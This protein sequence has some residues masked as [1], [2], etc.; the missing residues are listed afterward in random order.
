MIYIEKIKNKILN[1]YLI[2]KDEAVSLSQDADKE[3][4]YLAANEIRM[5]FCGNVMELCSI[6]NAKSGNCPQDCKWCSQSVH[7]NTDIEVYKIIDK[8]KAVAQATYNY[9]KG[10]NRMSLV[11]SGRRATT[12]DLERLVDIYKDIQENTKLK[13]CASL[14]LLD[15]K[16]LQVLKDNGVQTYHCNLETSRSFFPTVCTTHTYD[17]KINTIKQA[18][19][20]GLDICS[21]GIV[22]M[23]ETMEDRI[24]MAL[25][26]QELGVMSIPI[27]M[28]SI[29]EGTALKNPVPLSEEEML[30]T[31][32]LVRFINPKASV[33]FA[34]GRVLISRYQ[35]KAL[36]AGINSAIVGDLLTTIGTSVDEDKVIF[37]KA[38][39]ELINN[40]GI[41]L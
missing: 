1:G 26:L 15:A 36:K 28:L 31:F 38:G 3:A 8:K 33:R 10:V 7:H 19:S 27:N 22:G 34:A 17:E 35:D 4:L 37:K 13:L 6:T 39:F 2:N 24:D 12:K 40:E 14:G 29:V 41:R 18:Q 9:K 21:G 16:Q 23:G 20:I 5:H 25:V 11:A 30:T 32:A